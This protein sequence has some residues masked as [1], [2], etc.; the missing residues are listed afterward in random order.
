MTKV[1]LLVKMGFGICAKFKLSKYHSSSNSLAFLISGSIKVWDF[2][3]GQEIKFKEGRG[4]DEEF[5]ILGLEYCVIDNSRCIVVAGWHNT[6]RILAVS[7]VY[8]DVINEQPVRLRP[9]H[10]TFGP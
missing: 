9:P 5:T 2:G 3:S 1:V 10:R 6:L 7:S 4:A 8:V